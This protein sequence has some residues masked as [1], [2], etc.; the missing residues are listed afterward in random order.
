MLRHAVNI[1]PRTG[2][3]ELAPSHSDMAR[4]TPNSK[5]TEYHVRVHT[6]VHITPSIHAYLNGYPTIDLMIWY[7]TPCGMEMKDKPETNTPYVR[8]GGKGWM[9]D[10]KYYPMKS[11]RIRPME[12]ARQPCTFY[13]TKSERF[14]GTREKKNYS[15][16]EN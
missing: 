15:L 6:Y 14:A 1:P 9:G 16:Q 2:P 10:R 8:G 4:Q 3:F 7:A 5:C 13:R 12:L 11:P